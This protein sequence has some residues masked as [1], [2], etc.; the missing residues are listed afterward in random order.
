V[1]GALAVADEGHGVQGVGDEVGGEKEEHHEATEGG[2]GGPG[3]EQVD[4]VGEVGSPGE[5]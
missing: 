1:E 5:D 3:G 4:W 2:V